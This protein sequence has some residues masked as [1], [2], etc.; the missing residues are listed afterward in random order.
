M[1]ERNPITGDP[2]VIAPD[3]AQRPN[4]YRNGDEAC[5]FCPGNESMTPPEIMRIGDPWRVR[6]FPNKFPATDHHEVVV[7]S[8]QHTDTFDRIAHAQE[9]VQVYADRYHALARE[10][11]HVTIFK[12]HGVMAGASI[13]HAHSEIVATAFVPPRI[14]RESAAFRAACS[15]CRVADE[16]LI[17]ETANYRWIAPR[18]SMF[19]Y[20]QWIVPKTHA[21]E[22]DGPL[23]LPELLQGSTRRML[24]LADSFNW[25][26]MNFSRAPHAHWYVQ[27]FPRLAVHAGFELGSGSA[28]N[29]ID[30]EDAARFYR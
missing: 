10:A 15:L 5:P 25:I 1:I 14:E 8:P 2:I 30:P 7:E 20:E 21:P 11:A 3:R 17:R 28:I 22:M 29:V 23:E 16:P 18:G 9:A 13:P 6:V 19:A 26:F 27:L 4:I 12:N 24:A